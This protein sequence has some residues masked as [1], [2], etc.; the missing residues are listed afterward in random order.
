MLKAGSLKERLHYGRQY[1]PSK[2]YLET[3]GFELVEY[4]EKDPEVFKIKQ[5]LALKRIPS[6]TYYE[7]LDQNEF[8]MT[9]H[10]FALMIL[11]NRREGWAIQ[12]NLNGP[13]LERSMPHYDDEWKKLHEWRAALT[14]GPEGQTGNITVVLD[15]VPSSPLVP[16]KPKDSDR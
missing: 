9:C 16:E 8:L 5:F 6:S 14:K 13:M 10:E 1:G 7:W 3:L 2:E 15:A 4:V 12:D 11:G